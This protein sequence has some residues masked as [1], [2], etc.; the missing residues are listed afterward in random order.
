MKIIFWVVRKFYILNETNCIFTIFTII[1]V[2]SL[3][4][5]IQVSKTYSYNIRDLLQNDSVPNLS[6]EVHIEETI[7]IIKHHTT[8]DFVC[9]KHLLNRANLKIGYTVQL[10]EIKYSTM[11]ILML[12]RPFNRKPLS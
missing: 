8:I 4:K 5:T 3:R 1:I 7:K 2:V 10:K 12:V 11:Q 9:P 6:V